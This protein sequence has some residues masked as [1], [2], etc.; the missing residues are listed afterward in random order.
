MKNKQENNVQTEGK[1]S[2]TGK[3]GFFHQLIIKFNKHG[4]KRLSRQM[5]KRQLGEKKKIRHSM[6]QK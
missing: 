4:S 5:K 3:H 2:N 6:R 1:V